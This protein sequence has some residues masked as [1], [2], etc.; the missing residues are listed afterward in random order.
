MLQFVLLSLLACQYGLTL[1]SDDA[2]PDGDS[3][4]GKIK[5]RERRNILPGNISGPAP[6]EAGITAGQC[7]D[8]THG[9]PTTGPDCISGVLRCG[10]AI[11]GHS[12]GGMRRY[13][14]RFYEANFCT[15]ATTNH[16]GGEERVYRLDMPD[17]DWS[18]QVTFDSPCADLDIAALKWNDT[19]CPSAKAMV[20]QCEMRPRPQGDREQLRLVTQNETSWFLVVEGKDQEE[21]AFS[22]SVQCWPG[23]G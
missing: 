15:P 14:T 7:D 4:I 13:N 12:I 18:A 5:V 17:G 21:G 8:I 19:T 11:V 3:V 10:D 6:P 22:I 20:T 2:G 23:L 1:P 9:G 16:D